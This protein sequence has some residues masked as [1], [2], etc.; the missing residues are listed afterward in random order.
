MTITLPLT[1]GI[2]AAEG[3]LHWSGASC[4][5]SPPT[6]LSALTSNAQLSE[7]LLRALRHP[8]PER[9]PGLPYR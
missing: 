2:R 6:L 9:Y 8:S 5:L 1:T 4:R 3:I 7:S